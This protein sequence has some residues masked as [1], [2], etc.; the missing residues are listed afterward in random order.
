MIAVLAVVSLP[1]LTRANSQ[2]R[3]VACAANLQSL[4]QHLMD[5]QSDRGA[6]PAFFN[7]DDRSLDVPTIDQWLSPAGAE[8]NLLQCPSD[9]SGLFARSG[10]SYQ[11][12]TAWDGVSRLDPTAPYSVP[13][14]ADKAPL[15]AE[16]P[17]GYNGLFALSRDPG[18]DRFR[19]GPCD[20]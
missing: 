13:I 3:N 15:H 8:T 10:T 18:E 9:D 7:R 6:M 20:P 19:V 4:G 16:S 12:F 2:A 14:L 5:Y 11:W 1:L 17:M